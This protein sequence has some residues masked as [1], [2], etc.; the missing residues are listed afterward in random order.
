VSSCAYLSK[1]AFVSPISLSLQVNSAYLN[2]TSDN[3]SNHHSNNS[4]QQSAESTNSHASS[5]NQNTTTTT[6]ASTSSHHHHHHH[7]H[8]S[9]SHHHHPITLNLAGHHNDDDDLL[10]THQGAAREARSLQRRLMASNEA[11]HEVFKFSQLKL[12]KKPLKFSKSDIHDWG[13]FAMEQIAAE[14]FVIEYVGEVIRQS[15]ADHREKCYNSRGIGSSYMFRIDQET[16]VDATTCGNLSRFIN[17]SCD[18]RR[19]FLKIVLF[20]HF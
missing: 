16:I 17:H 3:P 12:R 5:S 6:D 15:V 1:S 11:I 19:M 7:H 2:P 9:T 4:N 8:H 14:E 10:S 20:Q 18:V 13:L